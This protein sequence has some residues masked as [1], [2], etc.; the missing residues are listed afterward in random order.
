MRT[1]RQWTLVRILCKQSSMSSFIPFFF[2]SC[3][4]QD[5]RHGATC[6]NLGVSRG[7]WEPLTL[8]FQATEAQIKYNLQ[9]SIMQT[10]PEHSILESL[11]HIFRF[12]KTEKEKCKK[13]FFSFLAE[14][15]IWNV[16]FWIN[17]EENERCTFQAGVPIFLTSRLFSFSS[18]LEGF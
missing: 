1:R 2:K 6:Y 3:Y 12:A 5:R 11:K 14:K 15:N 18:H 10:L 8:E 4:P 13:K 16:I 17:W 7:E 9:L